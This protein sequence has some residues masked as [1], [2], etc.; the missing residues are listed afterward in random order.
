MKRTLTLLMACLLMTAI[1]TNVAAEDA[2]ADG[3]T[4]D[5]GDCDDTDSTVY[6]GAPELEDGID[7]DCDMIIDEGTNAYDDDGD[8]VTENE[9]DCDDND[10]SI[11]PGAPELEDGIDNDCDT[12]IDEGTNAYDDDGDG[13]TENEGDCDDTDS[14]I[15]PGAPE[16]SGDGVDSD[17]DGSDNISEDE[18]CDLACHEEA[19]NLMDSNDDGEVSLEELMSIMCL[20]E[21]CTAEESDMVDMVLGM[22][23]TDS[24]GTLNWDEY[25]ASVDTDEGD[26]GVELMMDMA[27]A[28]GDGFLSLQEIIDM[29]NAGSEAAGEPPMSEQM[30]TYFGSLF[31]DAD[32][33][34]DALLDLDEFTA[35]YAALDS[36]DEDLDPETMMAMMDADGNGEL[37]L[38]EWLGFMA[39]VGEEPPDDEDVAYIGSMFDIVDTDDSGGL[40]IDELII[41][42]AA[43]DDGDDEEGEEGIDCPFENGT[44]CGYIGPYCD[45]EGIGYDPTRCGTETAHWCLEDGY[46]DTGCV[47]V[48]PACQAGLFPAEVCAAYAA[49]DHIAEH[50]SDGDRVID[51]EDAFPD[52]ANESVDTDG[53]GMGDNADAFPEDASETSDSDGDGM[54]DNADAFPEDA[55]ETSDSDGDGVGDNAQAEAEASEAAEGVPGFTLGITVTAMLGALLIA[56]RRRRI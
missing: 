2:D 54:G 45:E 48:A 51:D 6:P 53:D 25:W 46:G 12:L 8:G 55:S 21:N 35:F 9:G 23:D 44:Y 28:D 19:F 7:N 37:S 34:G 26:P 14:T 50:D 39:A 17:C 27:D 43:M 16:T 32:Y 3:Y 40:D 1:A 41:L 49:Y 47:Q 18:E 52:D 33:D 31:G 5:D 30:E 56:G 15:Y 29:M 11:Y 42:L 20:E 10:S 38:E 36:E 24:S 4:V 13:V 22:A